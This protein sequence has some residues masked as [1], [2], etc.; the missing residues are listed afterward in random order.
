MTS[1]R[2]LR[3]Q[4]AHALRMVRLTRMKGWKRAVSRLNL[5]IMQACRK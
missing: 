1:I 5:A 2:S 3:R 4:H